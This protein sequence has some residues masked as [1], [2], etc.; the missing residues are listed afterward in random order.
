MTADIEAFKF[1]TALAALMEF[2]NYLVKAKETAVY[3]TAAWDEAIRIL[4]LMMAPIMPHV[5]EELWERLGGAYSVHKQRWPECNADLAADEMMT[6][7][8]QV[9]GRVRGRLEL[10]AG[11]GEDESR[12]AALAEEN[13]QKFLEGLTIS[14]V[15]YVPG[16]LINIV[17]R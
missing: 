2:N 15:V 16:K 11:S 4:V 10:P 17:A 3:G 8:V 7:I 6:L 12:S 9:N 14:K 1:N 5:A 13:V